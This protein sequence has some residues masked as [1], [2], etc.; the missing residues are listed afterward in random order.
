[1]G[2]VVVVDVHE[3][4]VLKGNPLG[5]PHVR[6]LPVYLP[7]SYLASRRRFPVIFVLP[8]FTGSGE[9]QLN[10]RAWEENFPERCDRLIRKKKMKEAIV[11]FPDC[12]T[13]W[14]GSQ[15]LNSSAVGRYEDYLVR[16]LVR[17]VDRNY[18]TIPRADARA[19]TG[20]S[21]GGF[22]SIVQGMR[23]PDVFGLV[24]CRS[25]DMYFEYCYFPDIPKYLANLHKYG[26]TTKG[27]LRAFEKA[28]RK[29]WEH[30]FMM[31]Q[32]LMAACY[33]PNPRAPLGFDLP[34]DE[35]TG[36][37]RPAVWRKFQRW[38]PV[39]MMDRHRKDLKKL[40][41]LYLDCG[42]KDD[43]HL[44]LGQRMFSRKLKNWKI[45]HVYEEFED[46]HMGIHYR[47]DRV[48]ELLSRHIRTK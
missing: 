4:G 29:K 48:L 19:V 7:P 12:F 34:F 36:E 22:G 40:K 24:A 13:K 39:R 25:G 43:F 45:R 21:S 31:N 10:R 17:H 14:G 16:E 35:E 47:N 3:S 30:I 38:D 11:V 9:M 27:F 32:V 33:A 42:A 15:Y 26:G 2:G 37:L 23:H 1:M 8:G 5:D 28:P 18:R 41:F 20:W 44:Q 6:R 46:G